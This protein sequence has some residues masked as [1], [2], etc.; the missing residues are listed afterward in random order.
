MRKA[1]ADLALSLVG[2]N[3]KDG[4]FKPIIDIYNKATPGSNE[5][6]VMVWLYS[7]RLSLSNDRR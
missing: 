2:L 3:E 7:V 4:S 6:A 1:I 5:Y